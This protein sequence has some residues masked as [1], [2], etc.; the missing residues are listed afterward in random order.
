M[1]SMHFATTHILGKKEIKDLFEIYKKHYPIG[2]TWWGL[3]KNPGEKVVK[4][5]FKIQDIK[6]GKD[7]DCVDYCPI[8]FLKKIK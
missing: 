4:R 3:L 8:Y 6:Y 1:S 7:H 5:Y 2:K